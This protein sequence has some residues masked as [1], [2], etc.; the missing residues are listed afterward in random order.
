[1]TTAYAIRG[2]EEGAR[3]LDLLA[4]VVGPTTEAFLGA[5]RIAAGMSCL[6]VGCGAGHVSRRLAP[7]WARPA[8][9]LAWTSTR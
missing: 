3:R 4:Q 9:S 1:M 6:D 5:A 8:G 2:G 7:S